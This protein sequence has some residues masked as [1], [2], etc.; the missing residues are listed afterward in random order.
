MVR[1]CHNTSSAVQALLDSIS[2][3]QA[4]IIQSHSPKLRL[5]IR[6]TNKTGKKKKTKI[7]IIQLSV[8]NQVIIGYKSFLSLSPDFSTVLDLDRQISDLDMGKTVEDGLRLEL[9]ASEW[10][11]KT[12]PEDME[13]TKRFLKINLRRNW[14]PSELKNQLYK[15]VTATV[16]N[17][18]QQK[19]TLGT[20]LIACLCLLRLPTFRAVESMSLLWLLWDII[21]PQNDAQK[22]LTLLYTLFSFRGGKMER[23]QVLWRPNHFVL[24][25]YFE[26]RKWGLYHIPL[27]LQL[28]RLSQ[29]DYRQIS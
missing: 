21:Y 24:G 29:E 1:N 6:N 10:A 9:S 12:C 28:G 13:R 14:I 27:H 22:N 15:Y 3:L 4:K 17:A 11:R 19:K 16:Q 7:T 5:G 25:R 8:L 18:C 23:R 20:R 2:G 26:S